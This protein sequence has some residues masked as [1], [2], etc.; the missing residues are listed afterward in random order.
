[1]VDLVAVDEQGEA[2]E[3]A[4]DAVSG[5]VDGQ[6]DGAALIRHPENIENNFKAQ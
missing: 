6:D 1:M 5:L 2:V 3:Q 4:V